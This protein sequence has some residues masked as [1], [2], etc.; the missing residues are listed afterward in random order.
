MSK[1]EV[2]TSK[3]E[4]L[5][6]NAELHNLNSKPLLIAII[7]PT[8]SGKSSLAIELALR[9]GGEIVNCDSM[10]MVRGLDIG[11]A[12]PGPEEQAQVP[13]HLF[14]IIDP[15]SYYSAGA[16]M[17]DARRVCRQIAARGRTPLVVGGT[18]LYL[19]ALLE[20]VFDGPG[21]SEDF[22]ARL[23]RI[24]R[25]RGPHCLHRILARHDPEAAGKIGAS[26]L[27]RIIR[28]LEVL[29]STGRPISALMKEKKELEGFR[30]VKFGLYPDRQRLYGRI[31]VRAERMFQTGLIEETRRLLDSGCP[32]DAKAFEALGYRYA[33]RV[34]NGELTP[35]QAIEFTQRDTRRYAK[36]QLTWFR[37]EK[38][39][40][41]IRCMGD[42]P[43]V[44]DEVV[45]IL[46]DLR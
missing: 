12:K 42:D 30:V 37:R 6:S 4:L 15:D 46:G 27:T 31:D 16:Y 10:Q 41:W 29:Y 36:R 5:A 39:M 32:A 19:R 38:G 28:G 7:G 24:A 1:F 3:S 21:R 25:R 9:I 35:G 11:T 44:L 18:G 33:I 20:G 22:R 2:R 26:D 14:D 34:L 45:H 17:E 13:H 43:G 40:H 8:A 23:Q